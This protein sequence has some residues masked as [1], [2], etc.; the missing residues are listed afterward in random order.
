MLTVGDKI[1]IFKLTTDD[2]LHDGRV[3]ERVGRHHAILVERVA[4]ARDSRHV[5]VAGEIGWRSVAMFTGEES[6]DSARLLAKRRAKI[7]AA[8]HKQVSFLGVPHG[9]S[10]GFHGSIEGAYQDALDNMRLKGFW[11]VPSLDEGY[12]CGWSIGCPDGALIAIV[13]PTSGSAPTVATGIVDAF[14]MAEAHRAIPAR[15]VTRAASPADRQG[16]S[17]WPAPRS[18]PRSPA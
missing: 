16:N 2:S 5:M 12:V 10:E 3:V 7:H 13:V 6:V 11:L 4:N 15:N 17:K 8:I 1:H 14:F 18:R 9:D